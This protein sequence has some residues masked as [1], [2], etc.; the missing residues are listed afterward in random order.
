VSFQLAIPSGLNQGILSCLFALQTVFISIASF[1]ILK[2]RLSWVQLTG[3]LFAFG[4]TVIISFA[5]TAEEEGEKV[6]DHANQT[7]TPIE[8]VEPYVVVLASKLICLLFYS[9]GFSSLAHRKI[10][11]NQSSQYKR[12]SSPKIS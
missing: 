7:S 2:E 10:S 11:A 6:L 5:P 3:I 4:A 12:F 8:K 1:L 9:V